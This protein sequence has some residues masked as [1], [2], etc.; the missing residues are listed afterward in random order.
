MA[1]IWLGLFK[2]NILQNFTKRRIITEFCI[3]GFTYSPGFSHHIY[4][5]TNWCMY[6]FG[7]EIW[8]FNRSWHLN[9]PKGLHFKQSKHISSD[10]K[11]DD[12]IV[13]IANLHSSDFEI[14]NMPG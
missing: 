6:F 13:S 5:V 2:L 7:Q 12:S 11:C 3:K 9:T 8:N 10:V 4:P 1:E 14:Y